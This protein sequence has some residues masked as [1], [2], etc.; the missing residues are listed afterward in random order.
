ME[1]NVNVKFM[2][3]VNDITQRHISVSVVS[4]INV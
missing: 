4:S 3:T 1:Q 2:M